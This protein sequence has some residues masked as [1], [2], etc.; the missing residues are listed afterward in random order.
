M[1]YDPAHL[2]LIKG[3]LLA[4]QMIS[5]SC[6]FSVW[7]Q[8]A[9]TR[10]SYFTQVTQLDEDKTVLNN[11]LE[12]LRVSLLVIEEGPLEF[13]GDS[14][15]TCFP[16]IKEAVRK[17]PLGPEHGSNSFLVFVAPG[18]LS[19]DHLPLSCLLIFCFTLK[20]N[21]STYPLVK[22]KTKKQDKS[23]WNIKKRINLLH[24][25]CVPII[26]SLGVL[27]LLNSMLNDSL[28]TTCSK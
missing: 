6:L 20:G 7:V 25:V 27:H 9:P 16:S 11:N 12:Q 5:S 13:L 23:H 10:H 2:T 26:I 1:A 4:P 3:C 24:P 22:A 18:E 28:S 14:I 15:M 17:V 8:P 19:F 21:S